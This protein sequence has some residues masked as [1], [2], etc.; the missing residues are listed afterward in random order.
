MRPA[1]ISASD[2]ASIAELFGDR[3]ELAQPLE[4]AKAG[5]SV[6]LILDILFT[7]LDPDGLLE[8][9]LER[10]HIGSTRVEIY[11][12]L[13]AEPILVKVFTWGG[14][15]PGDR[16]ALTVQLPAADL[17]DSTP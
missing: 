3:F 16:N 12:Y 17:L 5:G 6:E 2:D 9:A 1:I 4:R 15:N 14:I 8:F 10:G 11:N 7:G 13:G